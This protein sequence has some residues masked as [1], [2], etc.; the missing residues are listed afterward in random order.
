M[1]KIFL[2]GATGL[3][4]SFVAQKLLEQKHQV[5]CLIRITSN[6]KW[7]EGLP[8]QLLTGSLFEPQS[9]KDAV[10]DSD[11]VLHV[12]GVTKAFDKTEYCR[13]NVETTKLLLDTICEVNTSLKR[14]LLVSSQ[15]AVGP[16]PGANPIDETYACHPLTDYGISKMESEQLAHR[17]M[18]KVPITIVRPPSVYG[19]RDTDVFNFFKGIRRGLNLQ[20]GDMDQL[21]S[22]V[23]VEDLAA[24]IIQAAFSPNSLGK[25]YFICEE[26]PYYWSHVA[27]I[28]AEIMGIK[29]RTIRIPYKLAIGIASLLEV[30]SKLQKKPTI[31]NRQ[32][33]LEVKQSFWSISPQNAINDFGYQTQFPLPKGIEKTIRWY[34]ETEWF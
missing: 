3:V 5:N 16:S 31:L 19:P 2:T 15:A 18:E 24:G 22:L 26:T 32:K 33:M 9:F 12:A 28:T 34:E 25:T 29:F 7:I 6:L 4:G 1:A 21:V 14:F 8:L 11:Y 30:Y 17:Y 23:Y 27:E 13:G 20:V 10:A